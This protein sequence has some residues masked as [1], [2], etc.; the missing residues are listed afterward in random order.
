MSNNELIN[1]L[2]S[3]RQEPVS[4]TFN[5]LRT[6]KQLAKRLDSQL[7]MDSKSIMEFFNSDSV[8]KAYGFDKYT[9]K[10][11][12]IPNTY[13]VYWN[14][15]VKDLFDR[16]Q[17]EYNDFWSNKRVRHAE[18][19][20]MSKAEIIT[21]ASV[22]NEETRKDDEK[23]RIAGVYVNRLEKGM[24]LQADPTVVYA[25]GNFSIQ[26][27]LKKHYRIDS[28]FNTYK[29]GGLPPGPICFPEISSIDAVLNYEK[30][31][32]LY[33]CAKPDFSGYHNFAKTLK[34]HNRNAEL[35]R[36]ELNKRKIYR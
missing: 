31:N 26:R 1:M 20:G 18:S 17:K 19:L 35:Y 24:R 36:R 3:G 6:E 10:C 21:L 30:H 34:Q 22:V 4:L 14:I 27:V 25:V 28:P 29:Y 16:M 15:S 2:R 9:L 13:E 5:N 23:K 12:F 33:F 32:Y 8:A 7:E 11:L